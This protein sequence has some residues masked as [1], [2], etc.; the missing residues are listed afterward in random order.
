MKDLNFEALFQE[1]QENIFIEKDGQKLSYRLC[2]NL[3]K[4]LSINL[5]KQNTGTII[6]VRNLPIL[7]MIL[8]CFAAWLNG[9]IIF[10]LDKSL[11]KKKIKKYLQQTGCQLLISQQNLSLKN[12][13]VLKCQDLLKHTAVSSQVEPILLKQ[14]A[15]L[16]ATSGTSG[17]SKFAM[18]SIGN[19]YYS[20]LGIIEKL[21]VHQ[22]SSWLLALPLFHVSGLAVLWRC[23]LSGARIKI[24]TSVKSIEEKI[25]ATKP[26][27]VS[28]VPAQLHALLKSKSVIPVL[29]NMDALLMGGSAYNMNDMKKSIKAKIPV[30]ISYGFTEMASTVTCSFLTNKNMYTSGKILPYRQIKIRKNEILTKGDCLFSGYLKNGNLKFKTDKKGWFYSGDLGYF[31]DSQ[32]LIINGRKDNMFISGGENIHPEEIE[33]ILKSI[34]EIE[35]AIVVPASDKKYGQRPVA[36]LKSNKKIKNETLKEILREYLPKYKIP[37]DFLPWPGKNIKSGIKVN[38]SIFKNYV[39]SIAKLS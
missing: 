1:H 34:P 13:S 29:K 18:L 9:Q 32:E 37:D 3:I 19:H 31:N 2:F 17:K 35:D 10:P 38:R 27:H 14:N 24:S 30:F 6:A 7:E 4:I 23:L 36:F 26:T 11:P 28:L 20:A 22:N 16:I 39:N 12:I 5:K 8:L 25:S 15:S 21:K 33:K